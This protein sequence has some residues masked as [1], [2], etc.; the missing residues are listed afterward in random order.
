M[1]ED[2]KGKEWIGWGVDVL[3]VKLVESSGEAGCVLGA[4]SSGL[5]QTYS[6]HFPC[7]REGEKAVLSE[8]NIRIWWIIMHWVS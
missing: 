6:Q 8:K 2:R 7:A 1:A 5:G 3:V 4:V